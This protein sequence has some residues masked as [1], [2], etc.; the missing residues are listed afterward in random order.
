[1]D[2]ING[3]TVV[4][5][6]PNDEL[7][8]RLIEYID[9]TKGVQGSTFSGTNLDVR[10]VLLQEIFPSAG[11]TQTILTKL[12]E[13]EVGG[14]Y[15]VHTDAFHRHPREVSVILNLNEGYEGGDFEFY[16]PNGKEVLQTVK[17]EK[18]TLIYFPSN[19]MYPHSVTPITKG[20]RYSVITWLA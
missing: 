4:K 15:N 8:T 2:V 1:M 3:V 11:I 19:F 7:Y 16:H 18:G 20:T 10:N 6:A 14:K 13:Y 5:S 12:V 9:H 17:Q